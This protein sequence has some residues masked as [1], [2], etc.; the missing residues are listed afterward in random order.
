MAGRALGGAAL[1]R[2][3]LHAVPRY[4]GRA[5]EVFAG[6][7]VRTRAAPQ[8]TGHGPQ[9]VVLPHARDVE[10]RQHDLEARVGAEGLR[11]R[12]PAVELDDRRRVDPGEAVVQRWW[13]SSPR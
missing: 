10:Q 6:L 8:V 5:Q 7:L 3:P 13:P 1:H 2:R 9:Q 12:D 11:G 4:R